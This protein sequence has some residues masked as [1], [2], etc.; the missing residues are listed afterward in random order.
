MALVNSF[1]MVPVSH[2]DAHGRR[3]DEDVDG[4]EV[5][6]LDCPHS[7]HVD[8]QDADQVLVLD[9][10]HGGPARP[11]HV[12]GKHCALN[13]IPFVDA[14]LHILPCNIMVICNTTTVAC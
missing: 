5:C 12:P 9:G 3:L 1:I 6:R 7:L 14:G 4:V 2:Q 13:E 10:L 8:V 11:V